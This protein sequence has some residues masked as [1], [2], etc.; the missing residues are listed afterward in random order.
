MNFHFMANNLYYLLTLL[1]S[2]ILAALPLSFTH[3]IHSSRVKT[4]KTENNKQGEKREIF[5]HT[6]QKCYNTFDLFRY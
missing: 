5:Q 2:F 6:N 4:K 3:S 1:N